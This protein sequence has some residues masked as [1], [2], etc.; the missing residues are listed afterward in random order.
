MRRKRKKTVAEFLRDMQ[1]KEER[2]KKKWTSLQIM[3]PGFLCIILFGAFLL[4]LPIC[5]ADGAWLNFT[6]ALF[7]ACTCVCVTGLVTV[8]PAVQFTLLGKLV[9]LF[10]IQIGGWGVIVCAMWFLVLLKRRISLNARVIIRDYF[11]MDTMSGLVRMLIYVV[12]ASLVVEGAGAVCYSFYFV[13]HYGLLRGC[14]YGIFHSVSAFCN[15]GIDILGDASLAPFRGNVWMNLVTMALILLGG[16]GFMVWRDLTG[17]LKRIFIKK[18]GLRKAVRELQL[19]TKLVVVMTAALLVLGTLLIFAVEQDNPETLGSL[20]LGQ[21]WMAALFQSVTTRTAGFFTISQGGLREA[22]K[23]ICCVLMFIGGSPVGT[24]GGVKTVTAAVL[25]LTCWSILKGHRDT[26]CFQRKIADSTV[27]MAVVVFLVGLMLTL[28]GTIGISVLE[29]EV[30]AMEGLYEVVS[31]TATVGL[32]AGITPG[33]ST[34]G[35]YLIILLMYLGRIGPI[36]L[37]MMMAAKL[38]RKKDKRTLPEEHIV[39]G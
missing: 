28:V 20:P 22:S 36:T 35:K 38:G 30:S 11:N 14:W 7:T 39:V 9:M 12:K 37:P 6:D 17:F 27:R 3:V 23:M 21:K 33:L 29:P 19:Q 34:P 31:A 24:A 10:L 26:E 2:H 32:T 5:N 25:L 13:P 16:L 4:M 15:A 18:D 1:G 8:V